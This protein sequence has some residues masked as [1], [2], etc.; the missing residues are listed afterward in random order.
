M[1]SCGSALSINCR[2]SSSGSA[3]GSGNGRSP[4]S[5][6]IDSIKLGSVS[7]ISLVPLVLVALAI[8]SPFLWKEDK[9][10]FEALEELFSG[11]D[12]HKRKRACIE[13]R[14]DSSRHALR[15]VY[16]VGEKK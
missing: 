6:S 10:S 8:P 2:R 1:E 15:F 7:D 14:G 5:L 11:A 4:A 3:V 13:S 12:Y 16:E 9:R